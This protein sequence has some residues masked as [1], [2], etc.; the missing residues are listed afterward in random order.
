MLNSLLKVMDAQFVIREVPDAISADLRPVWRVG[1]CVVILKHSRASTASLRKLHVMSWSLSKEE[2]FSLIVKALDDDRF[3]RKL[4]VRYDPALDRA[5]DFAVGEK[6][7]NINSSAKYKLTE[8]GERFYKEIEECN[9]FGKI[10]LLKTHA[11]RF[12]ENAIKDLLDW[13]S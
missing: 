7:V 10:D 6:L 5:M 1:L 3:K 12:S 4:I 2:N 9:S 8:L 13:N 11:S